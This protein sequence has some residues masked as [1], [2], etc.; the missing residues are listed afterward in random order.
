MEEMSKPHRLELAVE[1]ARQAVRLSVSDDDRLLFSARLEGPELDELIRG[2]SQARAQLAE[3]V[4]PELDEGARLADV[5][6]DPSYLIGK[7]SGTGE[8]LLALRHPGYGWLGFR[9]RRPV[10]EQ[11][12]GRLGDWLGGRL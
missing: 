9:L 4:A 10:V 11:I 5:V 7:N 2:L 12:V 1:D 3:E 8:A 6:V